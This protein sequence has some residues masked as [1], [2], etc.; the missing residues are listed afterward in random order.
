MNY[1]CSFNK[2]RYR[3]K[4][5][6]IFKINFLTYDIFVFNSSKVDYFTDFNV[7]RLCSEKSVIIIVMRMFPGI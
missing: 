7:L 5:V 1:F 3:S 6:S 2:F 4:L